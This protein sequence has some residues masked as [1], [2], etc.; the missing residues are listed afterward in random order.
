[1]G[2]ETRI[3][4]TIFFG[5]CCLTQVQVHNFLAVVQC[6]NRKPAK[7]KGGVLFPLIKALVR[8]LATVTRGALRQYSRELRPLPPKSQLNS[9][10]FKAIG[11]PQPP[12]TLGHSP[13]NL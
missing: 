7:V 2:A 6:G 5:V 8:I 9:T 4:W 1:M 3:F 10:N 12:D 11:Q 13:H